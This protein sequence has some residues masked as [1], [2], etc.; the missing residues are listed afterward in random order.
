MSWNIAQKTSLQLLDRLVDLQA[1]V[2]SYM[3]V[4]LWVGVMFLIC[5]P[6]VIIFIKKSTHKVDMEH[7]VQE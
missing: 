7:L 3:D 4:F 6:F 2:L 1:T 5:V